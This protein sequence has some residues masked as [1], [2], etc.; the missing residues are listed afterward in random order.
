M[1]EQVRPGSGV[2]VPLLKLLVFTVLVPGSVTVWLPWYF[3]LSRTGL[4]SPSLGLHTPAALVLMLLGTSGYLWCAL[5]FAFTGRGT[6][7]PIDPPK[8]LVARGLYRYVRNPMYISVLLVLLGESLVFRSLPL[9]RY[10]GIVAVGFHLF[11]LLYEEPVLRNKFGASYEAYCQAVPRWI[12][13][14]SRPSNS[15]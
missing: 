11:V 4:R 2:V 15:N 6:P 12:P 14:L 10:T 5:D 13:R 1:G 8:I 9:L 7:A 3:Y